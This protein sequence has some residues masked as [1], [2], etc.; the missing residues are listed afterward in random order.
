MIVRDLNGDD[1][2]DVILAG[3]DYS[4]EVSTGYFDANKGEILF[5]RDGKPVSDLQ[6]PAQTGL[7]L[8]GMVESLLWFDGDQPMLVAGFNRAPAK[9]FTLRK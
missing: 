5:S 9:V 4:W 8:Q 1:L 6:H 2:P 7:L 3:N